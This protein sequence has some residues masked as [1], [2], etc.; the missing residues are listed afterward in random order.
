MCGK[1]IYIVCIYNI[2]AHVAGFCQSKFTVLF[3][4]TCLK[5]MVNLVSL[6]YR[7]VTHGCFEFA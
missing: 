3:L 7:L 2:E 4:G 1:T 5:T 6:F